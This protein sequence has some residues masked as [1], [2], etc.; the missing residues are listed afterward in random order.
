MYRFKTLFLRLRGEHRLTAPENRS[1]RRI[2]DPKRNKVKRGW[3]KLHS[4]EIR[5]LYS[6]LNIIRIMKSRCMS[7]VKKFIQHSGWTI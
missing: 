4:E 1:L 2:S 6:S 7:G 5:K 3:R